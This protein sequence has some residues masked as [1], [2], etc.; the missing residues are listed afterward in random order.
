MFFFKL[1]KLDI[2]R[3]NKVL[4]RPEIR[5]LEYFKKFDLFPT[6]PYFYILT[7]ILRLKGEASKSKKKEDFFNI[8]ILRACKWV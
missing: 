8:Y 7:V 4:C 1:I 6:V 2:T 3:L 5:K